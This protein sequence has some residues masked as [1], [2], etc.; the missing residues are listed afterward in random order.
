MT[1]C[2]NMPDFHRNLPQSGKFSIKYK[3]EAKTEKKKIAFRHDYRAAT[4][5]IF[6]VPYIFSLYYI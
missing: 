5:N 2:F 6:I 3:I 4:N 1:I